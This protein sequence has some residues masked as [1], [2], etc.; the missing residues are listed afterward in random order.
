M[1]QIRS[2]RARARAVARFGNPPPFAVASPNNHQSI[3]ERGSPHRLNGV[4]ENDF[5][6]RVSF[7]VIVAA[8]VNK[9]HLFQHCRLL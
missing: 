9:F 3:K 1:K 2:P 8:V 5:L 7:R 6:V 4:R